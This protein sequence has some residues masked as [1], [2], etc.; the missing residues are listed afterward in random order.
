MRGTLDVLHSKSAQEPLDQ[1]DLA[2]LEDSTAIIKGLFNDIAELHDYNQS[3]QDRVCYFQSENIQ[4][5]AQIKALRFEKSAILAENVAL[6]KAIRD[7]EVDLAMQ[8]IIDRA[9]YAIVERELSS[10]IK[11]KSSGSSLFADSLG[12]GNRDNIVNFKNKLMNSTKKKQKGSVASFVNSNLIPGVNSKHNLDYDDRFNIIDYSQFDTEKSTLQEKSNLFSKISKDLVSKASQNQAAYYINKANP[13]NLVI[14]A[15]TLDN[16]SKER[17]LSQRGN[18]LNS[19]ELSNAPKTEVAKPKPISTAIPPI[20]KLADPNSN[21]SKPQQNSSSFGH[22]PDFLQNNTSLAKKPQADAHKKFIKDYADSEKYLKEDLSQIKLS[23]SLAHEL[24]YANKELT[25][26]EMA[27]MTDPKFFDMKV[28]TALRIREYVEI[29]NFQIFQTLRH[30]FNKLFY[31]NFNSQEDLF[32][33]FSNSITHEEHTC[34]ITFG[35]AHT[36]KTFTLQGLRNSPGLLPNCILSLKFDKIVSLQ[37]FDVNETETE[38]LLKTN[39]DNLSDANV[40]RSESGLYEAKVGSSTNLH[41]VFKV[42]LS[43]RMNKLGRERWNLVIRLSE[44]NTKSLTFIDTCS[45]RK[46]NVKNLEFLKLIINKRHEKILKGNHLMTKL[47]FANVLNGEKQSKYIFN[48]IG[49]LSSTEETEEMNLML[50]LFE[51]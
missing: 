9:Y 36:G 38:D 23:G 51:N 6:Q 2:L 10:S 41:R 14:S 44:S 46:D 37:I 45:L 13:K 11:F 40:I 35:A 3:L 32:N 28:A 31:N 39:L 21:G 24:S 50:S 4:R 20:M 47:L 26:R 48:L 27:F 16:S 5:E 22:L 33:L 42:V 17:T 30:H 25:L 29:G 8:R 43:Q 34:F 19:K 7:S 12:K 1:S 49:H 18:F 15:E